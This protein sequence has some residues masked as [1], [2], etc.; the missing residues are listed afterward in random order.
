MFIK[1]EELKSLLGQNNLEWKE[2][3]GMELNVSFLKF[4]RYLRKRARGVLTYKDLGE[5]L[6]VVESSNMNIMYMGY[7]IKSQ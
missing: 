7:A 2:H 6:F 5:R 3:M 4:L 1:P